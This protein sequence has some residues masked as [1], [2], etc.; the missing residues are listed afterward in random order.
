[1]T[2]A[3]LIAFGVATIANAQTTT[4]P[5]TASGV[6]LQLDPSSE[7]TFTGTSTMH[8]FKCTT[9]DLQAF[10]SVDS[11]Y[12]TA[13]LNTITHPII[14]VRIVIPVKSLACGGELEGNM[15]KTLRAK[16]YPT[17]TY[18]LHSYDSIPGLTSA[19]AFAMNAK[20]GLTVAGKDK[21]VTMRVDASRTSD[22]VMT[23]TGE[24]T[25]QMTD[26]GIK[27]P[28]FMLGVLRVGNK[29]VV[30]FTLKATAKAVTQ[31]QAALAA[32]ASVSTLTP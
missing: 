30:R 26:F 29:I 17:I 11:S 6:P 28:T 9:H 7:L 4:S 25:I 21:E 13:A 31:A 10:I 22:S 19:S 1:M 8:G 23:A 32:P 14:S 27:P 16:D 3:A 5:Q 18:V 15:L 2:R 12:S 24:E 20:G